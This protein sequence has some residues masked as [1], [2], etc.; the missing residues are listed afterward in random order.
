MRIKQVL[1][2]ISNIKIPIHNQKISDI[3]FSI[4][5]ILQN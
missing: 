2:V 3:D 5:E 4:L 1:Q